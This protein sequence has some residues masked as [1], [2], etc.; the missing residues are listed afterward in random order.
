[1]VSAFADRINFEDWPSYESRV[2][3]NTHILLDLLAA[4][5]INATFFVL[6]WVAEHYPQLVKD[7]HK[8]GHEIASHGYNHRLIY[9]LTP[10]EFREDAR[11]TKG[12]LED[13]VGCRVQGYRA[14]SYSVIKETLWALDILLEE[15]YIY[16]SSIFPVHHDRYG[17][18]ESPRFPH[19]IKRSAG[20]IIEFPPSTAYVFGQKVPVAGGGYLR[21][22]PLSVTKAAIRRINVKEGQVA[23]VYIHPWEIDEGQPRMCG[24][25]LSKT[26]HYLNLGSTM[27]KLKALLAEFPF[28]PLS[29]FIRE[30][31]MGGEAMS[32]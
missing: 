16:D 6:G 14:T 25:W 4:Q 29:H 12:I 27:S 28:R 22:F 10:M 30:R 8:A 9:N 17:F 13:I 1:M 3:R 20:T 18:P 15:G 7:I 32:V 2:E 31:Q 24:T 23:I 11:R 21:L 19:F 26:R 5:N